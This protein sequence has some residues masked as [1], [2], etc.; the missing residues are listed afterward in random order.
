MWIFPN[1]TPSFYLFDTSEDQRIEQMEQRQFESHHYLIEKL[2]N[3][4]EH[5]FKLPPM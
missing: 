2:I 3:V 5:K 4:M 1:A